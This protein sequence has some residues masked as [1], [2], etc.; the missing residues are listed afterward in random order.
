MI[1][2]CVFVNAFACE[3]PMF[4]LETSKLSNEFGKKVNTT[5]SDM[6]NT[7]KYIQVTALAR[8]RFTHNHSHTHPSTHTCTFTQSAVENHVI[9]PARGEHTVQFVARLFQPLFC[10]LIEVLGVIVAVIS[11]KITS[12][13]QAVI[14][15]QLNTNEHT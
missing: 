2:D 12:V 13:K 10:E 3:E 11:R 15:L 14:H 9:F 6:T 5:H 7:V 4:A 8:H 1:C